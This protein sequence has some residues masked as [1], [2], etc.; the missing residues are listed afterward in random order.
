MDTTSSFKKFTAHFARVALI[1]VATICQAASADEHFTRKD[2]GELFLTGMYLNGDGFEAGSGGLGLSAHVNDYFALGLEGTI[3]GSEVDGENGL[4]YA[5]LAN[6]EYNIL[7]SRFTPYLVASAGFVEFETHTGNFFLGETKETE[8]G[9]FGGGAGLRWNISEHFL[10]R[11]SYRA[12]QITGGRHG[13]LA[14]LFQI[15]V[16]GTF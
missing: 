1:F 11:G 15:G 2:D 6:V 16:G 13:G 9:A 8:R 7:K 5:F 14:H 4:S 10:I 3:G 12:M